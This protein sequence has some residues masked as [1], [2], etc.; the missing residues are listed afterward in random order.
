[1]SPYET[2]Y[3]MKCHTLACWLDS[4]EK[5]LAS[6]EIVQ[7]TE[8]KVKIARACL[9]VSRERKKMYIDQKQ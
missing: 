2:L 6:L 3:G 7:I 1:M 5:Q 8:H 4:R 9:N